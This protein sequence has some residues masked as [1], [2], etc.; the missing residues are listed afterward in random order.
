MKGK[1][2][3]VIAP[4]GFRDEELFEPMAVFENNGYK[5]DIVSTKKGLCTGMLGAKVEVNKTIDEVDPKDYKAIVIVGGV[6]SPKYL[7]HNEKLIN[8]VKEFYR[9]NKTVAAIC[10]SPVVLAEAGILKDK[11]AT[12]F[13][14]KEALEEFKKYGVK[15]INKGVVRVGKIV[16]A[17]SPEYARVFGYEVLKTL[18]NS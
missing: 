4:E 2:L 7:W 6:G 3:M 17:K 14:A 16:T 18:E 12:V 1:I 13:P 9:E 8:L 10:L 15:Y 5:V 11:E